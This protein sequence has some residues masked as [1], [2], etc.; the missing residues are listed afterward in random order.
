MYTVKMCK[1]IFILIMPLILINVGYSQ[2][3][4]YSKQENL[5]RIKKLKAQV[6][7]DP[8]SLSANEAYIN[9]VGINDAT[10]QLQYNDLTKLHPDSYNIFF[11][12]G[13][14]YANEK[15]VKAIPY[16]LRAGTLKPKDE[17]VWK[18]LKSN[19]YFSNNLSGKQKHI[20]EAM[21]YA[22]KDAN[23][24]FDY[25]TSFSD[26]NFEISDSLFLDVAKRFPESERSIDALYM[27][28][29]HATT[30]SEKIAY[31]SEIENASFNRSSTSYLSSMSNYFDLLINYYPDK[32]F[33][34]ALK[35][36]LNDK[37]FIDLWKEKLKV[38]SQ[39]VQAKSLLDDNQALPAMAVLEKIEL[40]NNQ[41]NHHIDAKELLAILKADA[42]D[43]SNHTNV[44]FDSLVALYSRIPTDR[45]SSNIKTFGKKLG[46][47][48]ITI[49]GKIYAIRLSGIK[50]ATNFHLTNYIS[51]R[52]T[53]LDDYKGKVIL[54]TYWFPLCTPCRNEFPHFQSVIS[55]I[56]SSKIA[57]LGLNLAPDQDNL[58]LPFLKETGYTF[59]P[60]RDDWKRDK[61][62]LPA[63]GAPTNYLINQKGQ[64]VFSGFSISAD[65]EQTLKLMIKETLAAKDY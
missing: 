33:K 17:D 4:Q 24:A 61:G 53:S 26:T 57:Y 64:I 39:F 58:V 45:L 8:N 43:K 52:E 18:I 1:I 65:N 41:F 60:V 35:M 62:N 54:L 9:A 23:Y 37:L 19:A 14:A 63:F 32:G 55:K 48:S 51:N 34:L 22:P 28:T 46:L 3:L 31:Y 10:L 21:E 7:L 49:W 2:N 42:E 40:D 56:D 38:A 47:D 20:R 36:V 25:A 44:A 27:L 50:K 6:E 11:A 59:I 12:I 13:N 30:I 16:L 5:D 29:L 15:D